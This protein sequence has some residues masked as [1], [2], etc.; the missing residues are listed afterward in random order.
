V[1]TD[2]LTNVGGAS[3]GMIA[4]RRRPRIVLLAAS[5]APERGSEPGVGWNRAVQAAR[6]FDTWVVCTQ[7]FASA[8]EQFI[9]A[10]GPIEGLHFAFVKSPRWERWLGMVPGLQYPSYNL[11][12][13]RAFRVVRALHA[14]LK[15]DL[16]HQVTFCGY[17]EPGYL[18]RLGVPF[19]W[20]PVGGTQNYPWRFLKEAGWRGATY[21]GLRTLINWY[22]LLT[23][24]R[25]RRAASEATTL[26]AA[27]STNQADITRFLCRVPTVLLETGVTKLGSRAHHRDPGEPLRIL[28]SGNLQ[29]HK[30]LSLLLKAL[31][32]LPQHVHCEVRV[33]GSG[34]SER[35]WRGLA[36]RLGVNGRIRWMG[37]LPHAQA[38]QQYSWAHALAFT[39]LRDTSGNVVLEALAAGVPVVCL[40]HQGV[41][42]IVTDDS[43]IRVPVTDV[44]GVVDGLAEAIGRLATDVRL[45]QRLSAG[46]SAR[47][48]EYLWE[49]QGERMAAIYRTALAAGRVD[50][51][52]KQAPPAVA[53]HMKELS[54]RAASLTTNVVDH[55]LPKRREPTLGILTYH[56]IAPHVAGASKP[57]CNVRPERFR[58]QLTEL[59]ARGFEV[60]PLSKVLAHGVSSIAISRKVVVVT[61]DDGYESVY[62]DAWPVLRE[63]GLP[64]TIF[65]NTKY[66]DTTTPFPFDPWAQRYALSVPLS[67]YRPLST[68]Q[69]DEMLRSDLIELGS[70]THSHEDFRNRPAALRADVERSLE[71]LHSRF[72]CER[73]AFAFPYGRRPEGFVSDELIAA[74]R[75]AGVTCSLSCEGA[76]IDAAT[77]PF[78]W[79]RFTAYDWDTGATLAAKLEGRYAW[80]EQLR[81][82]MH[83]SRLLLR[84]V[85]LP[86]HTR[87]L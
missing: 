50:R 33:L 36:E 46:A 85:P 20:G 61:F 38:M 71:V 31:A 80:V 44:Q 81:R 45:W 73:P 47:A 43:G 65:V 68:S 62:R 27:N 59:L 19:I 60:W 10:H 52:R 82:W 72:G 37:R 11:W 9:A 53:S 32:R 29:P 87:A 84:P 70:H 23:S 30:A 54:Q 42:D 49:R 12:H 1:L 16:A 5:C 24:Q 74:V 67:T 4:V 40:D 69:C 79:G 21:E 13:R 48:R 3:Q 39:S 66:L 63:L 28:W 41:H 34:P 8:I 51:R 64:A 18:W 22:Q 77:D 86:T 56:R 17:R 6:E 75:R 7:E 26:L 2:T 25:V 55:V 14:R 58:A 35:R 15:F 78:S 83:R 76:P 57:T